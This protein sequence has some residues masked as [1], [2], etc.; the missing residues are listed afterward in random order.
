MVFPL[1]KVT[2][3][4]DV[5]IEITGIVEGARVGVFVSETMEEISIGEASNGKYTCTYNK[6]IIGKEVI[7]RVR[8]V[9]IKPFQVIVFVT[10]DI[11]VEAICIDDPYIY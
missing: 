7:V 4:D 5:T 6:S 1:A 9:G 2:Y 8:K 11:S 10:G 3:P